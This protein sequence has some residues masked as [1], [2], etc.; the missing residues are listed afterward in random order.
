MFDIGFLEII[1]ILIIALVVIGPERMPEVARKVGQFIGKTRNFI[2]SVKD[3]SN[4]RDTV[5]ELQQS[6]DLKEEQDRFNSI[7]QDLYKGFDD[8]RDQINFDELQ[9]PFGNPEPTAAE[10]EAAKR[11]VEPVKD[12]SAKPHPENTQSAPAM[13]ATPS[14]PEPLNK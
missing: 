3:D 10:L 2:N 6:L 7:Q 8:V 1:V 14:S 4:L 5:R 13:T 12:D 11:Q 9:R